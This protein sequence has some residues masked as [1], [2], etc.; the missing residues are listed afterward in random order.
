MAKGSSLN[1]NG[2]NTKKPLPIKNEILYSR[3]MYKCCFTKVIRHTVQNSKIILSWLNAM[4]GLFPQKARHHKLLLKST[5]ML[6]S[7]I[8]LTSFKLT[9]FLNIGPAVSAKMVYWFDNFS[10]GYITKRTESRDSYM[11]EYPCS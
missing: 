5:T 4:F 8:Q 11:A 6:Q 2:N 10:S 1:R 9:S 7:K 3:I